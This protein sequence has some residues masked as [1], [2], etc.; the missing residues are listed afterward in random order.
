M[1]R[2]AADNPHYTFVLRNDNTGRYVQDV[3]IEL[4]SVST[5]IKRTLAKSALPAWVFKTTRDIITGI[6]SLIQEGELEVEDFLDT[7]T[8]PDMASEWM[9]ENR[10]RPEDVTTD[11]SKRGTEKHEFL[12]RLAKV[13]LK[14]DEETAE[15]VA[16]EHLEDP[17][18]YARAIAKWWIA[19]PREIVASE[20][21]LWSLR[22][23]TAGQL[24]I[25]W[26]SA[27]GR[28]IVTD[29]KTRRAGLG[30]YDSDFIQVAE[31]A[32][33][34]REMFGEGAEGSILLAQDDGEYLEERVPHHYEE[35]FEHLKCVHDLLRGGE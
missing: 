12:E 28:T 19:E 5:V 15:R 11:A 6:A 23:G 16:R 13:A 29:L 9:K 31:Y 20:K 35:V 8:D 22:D 21:N 27:V 3:T 33:M 24:D 25:A 2:V 4:P 14:E 10:L 32:R 34:W 7:F 26:R 17:D 30:V 1:P 18:P